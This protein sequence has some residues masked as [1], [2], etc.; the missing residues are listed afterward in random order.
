MQLFF[1]LF[2]QLKSHDCNQLKNKNIFIFYY[3]RCSLIAYHYWTAMN[4]IINGS[5]AIYHMYHN[6]YIIPLANGVG[7][8]LIYFRLNYD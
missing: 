4:K 8:L 3:V 7:V 2:Y 5:N 6:I 1:I